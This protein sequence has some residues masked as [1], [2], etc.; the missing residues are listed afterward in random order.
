MRIAKRLSLVVLAAT[1]AGC[2]R[3]GG[4][5]PG[6][7]L[8]PGC[9]LQ[10]AQS[11]A[12]AVVQGDCLHFSP[13]STHYQ[14]VNVQANVIDFPGDHISV[15]LARADGS[16]VGIPNL[17]IILERGRVGIVNGVEAGFV[18]YAIEEQLCR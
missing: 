8:L 16:T 1:L 15:T 5:S 17:A 10:P 7:P 9:A 4:G 6:S 11:Y 2:H 3:H 13:C 14:Y 18:S 12:G